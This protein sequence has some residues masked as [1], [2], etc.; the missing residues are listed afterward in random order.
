MQKTA[1][2]VIISC[3]ILLL[4]GFSGTHQVYNTFICFHL[5]YI[6]ISQLFILSK[7][8]VLSVKTERNGILPLCYRNNIYC[9]GLDLRLAIMVKLLPIIFNNRHIPHIPFRPQFPGAALQL[10]K[11]VCGSSCGENIDLWPPYC[12]SKYNARR[13]NAMSVYFSMNY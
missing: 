3:I 11:S 13:W 2:S 8:K 6:V 1:F 7:V 12:G 9:E 5:E 10:T 4:S